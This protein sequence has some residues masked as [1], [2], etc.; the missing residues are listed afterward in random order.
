MSQRVSK[1][2]LMN[3]IAERNEVNPRLK[4]VKDVVE[5]EEWVFVSAN[6]SE[7][8]KGDELENVLRKEL[9]DYLEGF[10]PN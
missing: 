4:W 2:K 10:Y 5:G 6:S 8:E 3:W 1:E 9:T 7:S